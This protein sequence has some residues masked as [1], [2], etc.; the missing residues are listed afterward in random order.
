M[1]SGA[2]AHAFS[3][4]MS[5]HILPNLNNVLY[6]TSTSKHTGPRRR[7]I[8]RS[9]IGWREK[10]SILYK[11]VETTSYKTRFKNLEGKSDRENP[12]RTISAS[13]EVKL[14]QVGFSYVGRV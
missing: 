14:L 3:S 12:K 7:W 6:G 5:T 2:G 1:E 4:P 9:H 10:R 11:G 13:G 8:V